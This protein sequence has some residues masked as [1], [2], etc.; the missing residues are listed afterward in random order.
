MGI[1]EAA[2][3]ARLSRRALAA[4]GGLRLLERFGGSRQ[5][6][7]A[8]AFPGL[9]VPSERVRRPAGHWLQREN[10]RAFLEEVALRLQVRQPEDWAR[11]RA[12][13]I[14]ALG[15]RRALAIFAEN[16]HDLLAD[17]FPE[18][19]VDALRAAGRGHWHCPANR[20]RF[21]A[22]TAEALGVTCKEDWRRV[23]KQDLLDRGGR[24]LF[25]VVPSVA[26]ALEDAFGEE[27]GEGGA[28]LAQAT[29]PLAPTGH[30]HDA[31]NVRKHLE[32][33][34]AALH[35]GSLEDWH[36]VS[37]AQLRTV[38]VRGLLAEMTLKQALALAYPDE[39]WSDRDVPKKA[40]QRHVTSCVR[41]IFGGTTAQPAAL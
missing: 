40:A 20:R 33:M 8:D 17:A 36:R 15:G 19:D 41:H 31:D 28:A 38:N 27:W 39:D 30:W 10:R 6:L 13:D 11:V 18:L 22:T 37:Y 32:E 16:K 25:N 1:R 4:R 7:L 21:L 35:L 12:R 23:S 5:A 26:A 34:A 9:Q 14:V 29:R 24:G 3:W 2:D